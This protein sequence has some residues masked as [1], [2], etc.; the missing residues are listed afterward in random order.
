VFDFM[1]LCW[2]GANSLATAV[3]GAFPIMFGLSMQAAL[4]AVAVGVIVGSLV[5]APM[6][7]FGPINGTNN[8][9]SSSAHF[10]VVGR[11]VGSFLSLLTAIAFFSISVW[12]SG[13]AV[14]GAA[15]AL[16]PSL[17][18]SEGLFAIAYGVFATSVLAISVY[19][20]RIMLFVNKIA[21][22]ASSILFVLGLVAFWNAFDPHFAGSGPRLGAPGFWAVFVSASLI[23]LANPI[24]FGAFLG[25][26]SRY[27]PS[28]THKP[29]LIAA[30]VLAQCL[31]LL[32][33]AF[34]TITA[35]I[36]AAHAPD[37]LAKADYAGGL[38]A[39]SPASFFV[40]MFL[41]AILSGLS[42]GTT[43]LYGTG[44]D[45]SSV[46]PRLSRPQATLLIGVFAGALIFVGRFYFTLVD[47]ITTFISLI[48][49]T[50][51]PW[52][53]VMMIGYLVRRGHYLSE[54]MQV[55]NRGRRGGA[56]WFNGGWNV[57]GTIAWAASAIIA[58]LTVNS[59]GHFVGWLGGFAG[60]L[61]LSLLAALVLPAILYPTCLYLF[62][63]P[64]SVYGPRG[65]R[66]VRS[67]DKPLAPIE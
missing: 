61:D 15:H 52:M 9:V 5:L 63:E 55:F 45:F 39:V 37:Y 6:A 22:V 58:L 33:F 49:V 67:V 41:L 53:V 10:G 62:P 60:G 32:P 11:I 19:G 54:A 20:F 17:H 16:F 27:L 7:V 44:L 23:A 35:S 1:R 14:V 50:T 2:G 3:L 21:V 18:E 47:S 12:S 40:P 13:D 4:A 57:P 28:N 8:A 24:S 34:G 64:R 59:P 29:K 36:I 38:L 48:V 26:W 42:T 31:T 51:T 30:T 65:A 56:Y 43:S 46:F 66:F 25:D